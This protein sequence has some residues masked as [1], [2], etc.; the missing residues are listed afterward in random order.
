MAPPQLVEQPLLDEGFFSTNLHLRRYSQS[1][2]VS[3][4]STKD[5]L[6]IPRARGRSSSTSVVQG[7]SLA[8][9]ILATVNNKLK[10]EVYTESDFISYMDNQVHETWE[11]AKA[12]MLGSKRLLLIEELP[13]DRQENQ[14]V[15]SGYRF[16]R[17]T[18][19]CLKS[20]FRL[21]NET[22]N[23]WSHL[24]GFFFFSYLSIHVFQVNKA[25]SVETN[26]FL[27]D[28]PFYL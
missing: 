20:L 12:L 28:P 13:K 18:K 14:Y 5:S 8:A 22:M 9:H 2:V 26:T 16:Y 17:S 27:T 10:E 7:S 11:T 23:I 21:H 6:T 1:H 19:E 3:N 4:S 15:L 25:K 24:L